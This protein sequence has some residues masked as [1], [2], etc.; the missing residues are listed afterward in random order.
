M[1][2][3]VN[4]SVMWLYPK[5]SES[6]ITGQTP[7]ETPR[8]ALPDGVRNASSSITEGPKTYGLCN[9]VERHGN[10]SDLG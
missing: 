6:F 7:S 8:N 4:L 10:A 5:A 3:A 1:R 2:I 9:A